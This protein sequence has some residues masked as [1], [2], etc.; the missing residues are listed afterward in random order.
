MALSVRFTICLLYYLPVQ[1]KGDEKKYASAKQPA[2]EDICRIMRVV[3]YP[4]H[5]G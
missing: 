2:S 4:A 1:E 3:R 5:A